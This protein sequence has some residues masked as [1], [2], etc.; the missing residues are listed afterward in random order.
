MA[1][2]AGINYR[3]NYFEF[4]KLTTVHGEPDSESLYKL[5]N[6][7][8]SNAQVV[9]SNLSGGAHMAILLLSSPMY[10]MRYSQTNRLF[11]QSTQVPW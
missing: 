9:Y 7:L 2:S 1:G 8:K 5:H 6:D 10:N 11:A 4:P 3:E